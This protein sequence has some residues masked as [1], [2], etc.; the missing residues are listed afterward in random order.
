[1]F[2]LFSIVPTL[3]HFKEQ[4]VREI[5]IQDSSALLTFKD[6]YVNYIRYLL[7]IVDKTLLL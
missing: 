3:I 1:M 2:V 6:E 5:R 4:G 7:T